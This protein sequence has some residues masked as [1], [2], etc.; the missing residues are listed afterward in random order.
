MKKDSSTP[1]RR[2][3]PVAGFVFDENLSPQ[4][5]KG[6][7]LLDEGSYLALLLGQAIDDVLGGE[8]AIV[9]ENEVLQERGRGLEFVDHLGQAEP[10]QDLGE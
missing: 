1:E 3:Y 7:A 9:P 10:F 8:N 4:L 5:P 6:L 2:D